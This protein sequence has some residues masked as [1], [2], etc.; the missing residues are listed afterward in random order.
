MTA[1]TKR[2]GSVGFTI[3]EALITLLVFSFFMAILFV[4]LAHGFRT[5][6][7]AVARSDVTTEA[8]RLILFLE[9]ELRTSAYFSVA[10]V[11]RYSSG[12]T[13]T[14]QR[15]D[16]VSFVSVLDWSKP[17]VYNRMK[18]RP[19]WDRYLCY[20]ATQ[21]EPSGRL[22][23]LAISPED[24]SEV[25]SFPYPK[26]LANPFEFMV[27]D[28]LKLRRPDLANVR[29]LATKVKSFEV[30]LLPAGQE[31]EVK[32]LLRQNAIMSRRGDKRREGGTFELH[33][34]I[35]PQNSR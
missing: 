33:Y 22:V 32:T 7:L 25:G 13:S 8:R 18:A 2:R 29:V 3:T 21:E 24:A 31:V 12:P 35:H 30:E 19:E 9:S 28:P 10:P 15:R 4:T 17:D 6:S 34:R 23:R 16:G 11:L 26:F 1:R 14:R 27:D 5:F 20:Y